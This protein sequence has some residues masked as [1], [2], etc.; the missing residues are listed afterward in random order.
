M[1]CIS[2]PLEKVIMSTAVASKGLEG[3]VAT[4]SSICWIDGD[5]GVLS[6][7]GIDIHEL[8][9]K[10]TFE[11]TTYLLWFGKLPTTDELASFSTELAAARH[12]HP[13]VVDLLR[14]VPAEATPMQVL[15]TAT[16]LLSI[17]D[18]D[19]ADSS[20]DANVRKS[21]RLTAQIA[22]IVA[23]FDRIRKGKPVGE[24]DPTLTHAGNFLWM[25]NGEKPSDTATRAFAIALLPHADNDLS[26]STCDARVIAA[27]LADIHSAITGAIGAL[28][29]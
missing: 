26:A 15:R 24:A 6:Y 25:L 20:H 1:Y 9:S 16:S 22:M 11:E 5:A 19:E 14:S 2:H 13:K 7:R 21:F 23:L 8:A 17:Y 10:S 3:I 27:T 12:I 18:A 4:S 28:K 29:G